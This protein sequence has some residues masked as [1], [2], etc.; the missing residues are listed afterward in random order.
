MRAQ[1][2][3]E[4]KVERGNKWLYCVSRSE[5]DEKNGVMF[6]PDLPME[7]PPSRLQ[8]PLQRTSGPYA[9]LGVSTI[10]PK[11]RT[12]L[13]LLHV[14]TCDHLVY[15]NATLAALLRGDEHDDDGLV[16]LGARLGKIAHQPSDQAHVAQ[17]VRGTP[18]LEP[19]TFS[20]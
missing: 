20:D 16:E 9:W 10:D 12:V 11:H 6:R 15:A 1:W 8:M 2:I 18:T 14:A 7:Q 5:R 13:Q 4:G 19:I 17:A 3:C